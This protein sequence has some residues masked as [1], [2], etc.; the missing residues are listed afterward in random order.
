MVNSRGF[1]L[2]FLFHIN[3]YRY[4]KT[5]ALYICGLVFITILSLQSRLYMRMNYQ[6]CGKS[7]LRGTLRDDVILNLSPS[8]FVNVTQKNILFK[9]EPPSPHLDTIRLS[10]GKEKE[11]SG[12]ERIKEFPL[13]STLIRSESFSDQVQSVQI[14]NHIFV[15]IRFSSISVLSKD[16]KRDD[17]L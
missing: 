14:W 10:E 16:K 8:I 13:T 11:S 6:L 15:V 4:P 5:S 3:W 9:G 7:I 12:R 1:Y 2:Q 17:G